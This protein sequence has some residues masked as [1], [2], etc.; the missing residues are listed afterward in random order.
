[1]LKLKKVFIN[2]F[3]QMNISIIED[4][5]DLANRLKKQLE[6]EWFFVKTFFSYD[7]FMDNP[8]LKA[9]F[10]LIDIS[11]WKW[12]WSWFDIIKFIRE[13]K[14]L[15]TPIII[16]SAY[17]DQEKKVYWLNLWADDYLT[18]IFSTEELIARIRAVS[19]RV[20]NISIDSILKHKDIS[21]DLDSKEIKV[22]DNKI[23]LTSSETRLL[24]FFL[25]NKW[26][27]L[28]KMDLIS[29]VW[30]NHNSMWV[31]DNTINAT[32]SKIRR[33]LWPNF[34]LVTKVNQWYLL[35]E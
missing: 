16:T 6:K 35:E 14:K 24:I 15:K 11:L 25:S 12:N 26:K 1:M 5:Q 9:D 18:K 13:N 21:L 30:W 19:R 8:S 4:N 31:S 23:Y 10:F 17:N 28:T 27:I 2:K 22:W 33:K 32:I 29:S 34:N 3:K 7:S 20:N